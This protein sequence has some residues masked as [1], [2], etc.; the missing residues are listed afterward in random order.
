MYTRQKKSGIYKKI[1]KTKN[2]KDSL[3]TSL[4]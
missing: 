1:E 4:I 2:K 3:Y